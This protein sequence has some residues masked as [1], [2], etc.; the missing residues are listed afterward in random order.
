MKGKRV[1]GEV[2]LPLAG[3]ME[4]RKKESLSLKLS[5]AESMGI[6]KQKNLQYL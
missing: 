1:G 4:E 6:M 2:V 3:V 5:W